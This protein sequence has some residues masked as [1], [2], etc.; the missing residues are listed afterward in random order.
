MLT[1]IGF[2]LMPLT[3]HSAAMIEWYGEELY[4]DNITDSL[5][6]R[7]Y[8]WSSS[9]INVSTVN[10]GSSTPEGEL[11]LKADLGTHSVFGGWGIVYENELG[12]VAERDFSA[13]SAG[14]LRFWLF[15]TTTVKVEIEYGPGINKKI[16][17]VPSTGGF[18]QEQ[19]IPFSTFGAGIDFTRIK[20]P[21]EITKE[22]LGGSF[23]VDHIR[24]TK[25]VAGLAIYPAS[26]QVNPGRHRQFSIE[27]RDAAG[28]LILLNPAYAVTGGAGTVSIPSGAMGTVL[29]AGSSDGTVRALLNSFLAA[30]AVDV[31][32]VNLDSEFG[33]YSETISGLVLETD[34]KILVSHSTLN[35]E[36][37]VDG[38]DN[39][40]PPE[41]FSCFKTTLFSQPADGFAGW[42]IQWGLLGSPDTVTKDM[43]NYYDGSLRFWFKGPPALASKM[44]IAVRSGNVPAGKEISKVNLSNY[45]TFN[46]TWQPVVIPMLAFARPRPWADIS[47]TKV[48][49]GI[50]A[51]GELTS[52]QTF[53]VDNVRWDTRMP[54]TLSSIVVSPTTLTVPVNTN[55][56]FFATGFDNATPPVKIDV[57]PTWSMPGA[58]LGSLSRTV[59]PT[60]ILT[61]QGSPV[62][63]TV[64]A[65]VGGISGNANVSV[66]NITYSQA[67]KIYSDAGVDGRIGT[68]TSPVVRTLT[69]IG[70]E[71]RNGGGVTGDAL[72]FMRSTFTLDNSAT[73]GND[74]LALWFVEDPISARYLRFY[75]NGFLHF[76]V[77]TPVDLQVS[78]RSA[79]INPGAERSKIRLSELGIPTNSQWQE[80]LIALNTFKLREPLLDF[81]QIK[82]FF[83]IGALSAQV[84]EMANEQ[85]DVDNVEW[86]T[87]SASVPSAD[88]VYTGLREKQRAS[89]LVL[90]YNNDPSL[91]AHTYDQALAAM[92]FIYR[93]DVAL[94]ANIFNR[95]KARFDAG[96]FAGFHN[97][98]HA[99]NI[100]N[101][102]IVNRDA[103][104]NAW[105]LLALIHYK[106]IT[107]ATTYDA[108]MDGIANWLRTL[109]AADGGVRLGY[110][111][112]SGGSIIPDKSTEHN[113]DCY[114]AFRAYAIARGNATFNTYANQVLTWLNTQA[115][116]G[117]YFWLGRNNV[118]NPNGDKAL[119]VYSWA[120]LAL[121]S[122]TS[123]LPL[124]ETDFRNTKTCE[125]TNVPVD[126]FDFSGPRGNSN[127]PDKDAV[128]LEGTAQMALAYYLT[129]DPVKGLYFEQQLEKAIITTSA[130]GQGMPYATNPGTAYGDDF[131]M[132]SQRPAVASM[133]WYLFVKNKFNPF[134]PFPIHAVTIRNISNNQPAADVRWTTNLPARWV[135]AN[136]YIQIDAQPISIDGWGLQIYTDNAALSAVPRFVDATPEK[137]NNVDSNPA[138]LV[139]E[140]PGQSTSPF[141]LP[142]AWSVKETTTTAPNAFNPRV[143]PG[144]IAEG[145]DA[146]QWVFMKDFRTPII[147]TNGNDVLTDPVDGRAFLDGEP[148]VTIK[149]ANGIQVTQ[150]TPEGAPDFRPSYGSDYLYLEADYAGA[151]V[152]LTY[153][154][155]ITLEFYNQ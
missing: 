125:V 148:G 63:G 35:P 122:F 137:P 1:A 22:S 68:S 18:W 20:S 59:G 46:N 32:T 147:D 26:V 14:H 86:L 45:A 13:Y 2:L 133:A 129:E 99:D 11:I 92:N 155:S 8:S 120:P 138:G 3:A 153:R 88:K 127:P 128:W 98:Y 154:T 119:D 96:S 150:G 140:I 30:A 25:P 134:K 24:W 91:F 136:Q 102:L 7:I 52:N 101:V 124:A 15:S 28:E 9:S 56:Q 117:S 149:N 67:F 107:G 93:K 131:I 61:T 123:V 65:T 74:A 36:P 77:R 50:F 29:T 106:N 81:D 62:S 78:I 146:F 33:L 85:F 75:E 116:N 142:M 41:G 37:F 82:T 114:A 38:T 108:M 112:L 90:S 48:F 141:V 130:N 6:P 72:R 5:I 105:L 73:G 79:N 118:G 44:K 34:S 40:D 80:V 126:G 83:T 10:G 132:D 113:M 69:E 27:G 12:Q 21:F 100:N 95:Y 103:G 110:S 23:L 39:T 4:E 54:G 43:S 152:G 55:V 53:Y 109:Q 58:S 16:V 115:W 94:A 64:R 17:N 121:S 42:A 47:R 151:A 49:F 71:E 60:T 144:G 139:L 70:L 145:P 89:G 31:T 76:W 97:A 84:G 135:R 57:V 66:Q 19:I 51:E 111:T 87:A 143:L 104:P